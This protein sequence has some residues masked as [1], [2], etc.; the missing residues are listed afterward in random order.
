[1]KSKILNE[2]P[3]LVKEEVVTQ[4]VS[5]RIKQYYSNKEVSSPNKTINRFLVFWDLFWLV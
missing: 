2:L 3:Q 4:E 1:M 5:D